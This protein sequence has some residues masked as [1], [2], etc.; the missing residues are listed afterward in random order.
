MKANTKP[1]DDVD[2]YI[3][4][5]PSATQKLLK[6]LRATIQKAAP[7]AEEVISYRMPAYKYH[8]VLVF[9][10]GYEHHIGFYPT[11]SGIEN[12]K[13]E[14][15]G[16]KSSKGAVQFPLNKP[17]PLSLVTAIVKF[18]VLLNR[19]KASLPPKKKK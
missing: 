19:E 5:F 18:R 16:F 14:I 15:A 2:S 3:A 12:F 8:G 7:L 9:F 17:L 1:A 4:G 13:K 6:Q 11:A 10:A